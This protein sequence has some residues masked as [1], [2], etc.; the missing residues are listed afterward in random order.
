MKKIIEILVKRDNISREEAK[1]LLAEAMNEV[2]LAMQNGDD[3]EEVFT[4]YTGLESDFFYML[5]N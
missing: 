5:I 3:P 1:N 2:F 4:M